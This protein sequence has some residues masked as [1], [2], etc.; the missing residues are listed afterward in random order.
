MHTSP[1]AHEPQAAT[2]P[3][4]HLIFFVV[5]L[6]ELGRAEASLQGGL[7]LQSTVGVQWGD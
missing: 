1:R 3:S 4:T 5:L 2:V 7:S 6:G